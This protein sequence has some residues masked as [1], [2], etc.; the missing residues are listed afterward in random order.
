MSPVDT[1]M[2]R[3]DSITKRSTGVATSV[4][5]DSDTGSLEILLEAYCMQLDGI[6]NRIA[7][8]CSFLSLKP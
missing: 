8:V 6:R 3:S 2:V 5:L 1:G 4:P 7:L